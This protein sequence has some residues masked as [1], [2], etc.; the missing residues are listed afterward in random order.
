MTINWTI[1]PLV[2]KTTNSLWSKMDL[3]A[4]YMKKNNQT[5]KSTKTR[6]NGHWFEQ[7]DESCQYHTDQT[8][9]CISDSLE[10]FFI[11]FFN[12]QKLWSIINGTSNKL[13]TLHNLLI[14]AHPASLIR[15][16]Y[17][18]LNC[19]RRTKKLASEE[20][21]QGGPD[22]SRAWNRLCCLALN[23]VFTGWNVTLRVISGHSTT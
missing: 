18:A 2:K 14:K 19:R 7:T 9:L 15:E 22:Y 5:P 16:C 17:V 3:N 1:P 20:K 12:H 13:F 23:I 6:D 10:V 4:L 8:N 21:K 11:S